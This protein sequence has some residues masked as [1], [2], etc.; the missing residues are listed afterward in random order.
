MEIQFDLDNKLIK[1]IAQEFDPSKFVS[2]LAPSD[3]N[4]IEST[5]SSF[6]KYGKSLASKSIEEGEKT[7]DRIFEVMKKAIKETGEMSFPLMPQRYME[8]AYLSIQPIKRLWVLA[9]NNKFFSYML[10]GC[11]IY[12]ALGKNFGE[13]AANKMVCKQACIAIVD[14]TFTRF[15][16]NVKVELEANMA[17]DGRCQFKVERL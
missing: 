4:A 5:A 7:S 10:K 6:E 15:G 9:N 11:T 8:I 12:D 16:F 1:E 17:G 2:S 3:V 14:E 13:D